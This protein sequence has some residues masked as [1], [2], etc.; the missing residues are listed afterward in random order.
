M[1]NRTL[2]GAGRPCGLE[3]RHHRNSPCPPLA[4]TDRRLQP[5]N[6]LP[7]VASL[8]RRLHHGRGFSILLVVVIPVLVLPIAVIGM[9]LGILGL[10]QDKSHGFSVAGLLVNLL[11]LMLA[12]AVLVGAI[13]IFMTMPRSR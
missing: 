5:F 4:T 12:A 1:A 6:P 2:T 8:G 9:I 10:C 13:T 7:L 3:T 11:I